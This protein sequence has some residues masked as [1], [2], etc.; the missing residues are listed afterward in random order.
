M[1]NW[2]RKLLSPFFAA[3]FFLAIVLSSAFAVPS[4]SPPPQVFSIYEREAGLV[5]ASSVQ[6]AADGEAP[7]NS[8][9][10]CVMRIY[11]DPGR[12]SFS[13]QVSVDFGHSFLTFLNVS[14]SDITVGRHT[15]APHQMVSVGKFGNLTEQADGFKGVFYNIESHR[16]QAFGW[17]ATGRSIFLDITASELDAISDCI[18]R[19]QSGYIEVGNNCAAFAGLVWNSILPSDHAK[20]LDHIGTPSLLYQ[21]MGRISD[22]Y[23]GNG[24]VR[25]DY[26]PCCYIG[27]VCVICE[28]RY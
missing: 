12:V 11:S 8:D 18:K 23:T 6:P 24:L 2:T 25:A 13:P 3:V 5:P 27:S 17:Y 19:M 16:S 28:D 1:S 15:V 14:S 4:Q 20:Y 26:D 9:I 7:E 21:D 10:V 22:Y